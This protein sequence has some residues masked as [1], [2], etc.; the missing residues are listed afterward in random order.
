MSPGITTWD[1]LPPFGGNVLMIVN[2]SAD[3]VA[4]VEDAYRHV[5]RLAP[6]ASLFVICE[7]PWGERLLA[8]GV[9][10]GHIIVTTDAGGA[11]L[12]LNHFL[13]SPGTVRWALQHHF[14]AIV[15]TAPHSL[16]NEE[17]KLTFEQSV[18]LLSHDACFLAHALPQPFLYV[19]DF[20]EF[21]E[22]FTRHAKQARYE[23]D[24]R[25]VVADLHRLWV[26]RGRPAPDDSADS[27]G[28]FHRL[29][30]RLDPR[31]RAYDENA[32][33]SHQ[34]RRVSPGTK[35][36]V[37][38]L[39]DVIHAH[40][41]FAHAQHVELRRLEAVVEERNAA[42]NLRDRIIDDLKMKLN[43]FSRK[44]IEWRRSRG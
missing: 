44:L 37:M 25:G 41:E 8:M 38:H 4:E 9:I 27:T 14:R 35:G 42:V 19:F 15:G 6:A 13:E 29:L 7:R 22:R 17:V 43:P 39:R 21:I 30:S 34:T 18:S 33:A 5:R 32:E 24:A 11:D 10:P 16:Y 31:L 36:L 1:D 12:E 28:A 26:K 23:Q 3:H 40:A 20:D 2:S